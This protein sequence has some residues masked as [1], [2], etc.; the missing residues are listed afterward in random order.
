MIFNPPGGS[1]RWVKSP[2]TPLIICSL[3][4]ISSGR[5]SAA[6]ALSSWQKGAWGGKER[7]GVGKKRKGSDRFLWQR[8]ESRHR[9]VLFKR[10]GT[11]KPVGAPAESGETWGWLLMWRLMDAHSRIFVY[12]HTWTWWKSVTAEDG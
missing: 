1:R 12:A 8:A 7:R 2:L 6:G 9:G 5:A 11:G 10:A 3:I 4:S